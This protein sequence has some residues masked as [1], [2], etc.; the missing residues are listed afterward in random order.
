MCQASSSRS[1][2]SP[3][4]TFYLGYLEQA[5]CI[6]RESTAIL[7]FVVDACVL[8]ISIALL[9]LNERVGVGERMPETDPA[10]EKGCVQRGLVMAQKQRGFCF[11]SSAWVESLTDLTLTLGKSLPC[12]G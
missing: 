9:P 8:G 4:Q 6:A 1:L 10:A 2:I 3:K 7:R 5:D 12:P 11:F